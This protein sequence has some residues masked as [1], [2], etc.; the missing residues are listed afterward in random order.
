MKLIDGFAVELGQEHY[1]GVG[2]G[3]ILSKWTLDN[4]PIAPIVL[5]F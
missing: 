1:G 3:N 2:G 5:Y 4:L